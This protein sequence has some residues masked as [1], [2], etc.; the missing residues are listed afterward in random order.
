MNL[1]ACTSTLI[2]AVLTLVLPLQAVTGLTGAEDVLQDV[3]W[4][5]QSALGQ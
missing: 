3:D 1:A 4:N 5:C 2:H